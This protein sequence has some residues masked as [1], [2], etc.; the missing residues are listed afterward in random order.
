MTLVDIS[1][2]TSVMSN[3]VGAVANLKLYP[4]NHPQV[5]YRIDCLFETLLNVFEKVP[6]L[7]F[8]ILD[9]DIIV[10]DK[11]LPDTELVGESFIKILS[12][13]G[14]ERI[15]LLKNLPKLELY[16]FIIELAAPDKKNIA[17]TSHIKLG[18]VIIDG[19]P[20][21]NI[22]PHDETAEL[23]S[24]KHKAVEELKNIY[25]EIQGNSVPNT[26]KAKKIVRDFINLY[27]KS[28]SPLKILAPAKDDDEYTY[29]HITNVALLTICFADYLG[30]SGKTLE[31]I[32]IA[33]LLHD[34]GKMFIPDGILSK[35]GPLTVQERTEMEKHTLKG[36]QYIGH[37]ENI[38]KL[39]MISA[40]EHHIKYDGSGYPLISKK[41]QTNIV[42]QM[43]SITDV[44]DALR[45]KRSYR[46]AMEYDKILAILETGRGS[47]FNPDLIENFLNMIEQ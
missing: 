9:D 45:S 23:I 34:V 40:L 22:V 27:D 37:H 26:A 32:G 19:A 44:Y 42:S 39:T 31:D 12:N 7:T 24:F 35:P 2:I 15:T 43:I 1:R 29:V 6:E 10:F 17:A 16:Q 36:A 8:F 41:W 13:K 38:P 18:K 11:P 30:F 25:L 47:D 33:A 28:I 14:I 21:Q 20:E 4:N 46:D 3:L 5:F